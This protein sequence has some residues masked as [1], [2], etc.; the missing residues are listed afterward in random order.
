LT[1]RALEARV[2]GDTATAPVRGAGAVTCGSV[3]VNL[4]ELSAGAPARWSVVN[5]GGRP[6]TLEAVALVFRLDGAREPL[7][8]FRHGWQS[9]ST[10]GMG[11]LGVDRDPSRDAASVPLVRDLYHA[12]P[13]PVAHADELRSEWVTVLADSDPRGAPILVGFDAGATHDGTIRVRRADGIEVR[14]EAFLGGCILEPGGVRALHAVVVDDR[15]EQAIGAGERLER[16][17]ARV[18]RH[19]GARVAAPYRTGWC[20]WY[21]YFHDVTEADVRANLARAADWP[22][23]VFQ[24]DDGFQH[25]I[26]DWLRT[27]PRFPSGVDGVARLIATAGRQPGLW[28]APFL[29]AP[30]SEVA[31]THPDWLA[32][33]AGGDGPLLGMLNPPW[34]AGVMAGC[35]CS[36]RRRAP[37]RRTSRTLPA[38]SSPPA[39]P[40]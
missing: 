26:G 25:A 24:L 19:G 22:F 9:W 23:D 36:T 34:A 4:T 31:R 17:A 13:T 32:R 38:H 18:G 15:P 28:I 14:L 29:V 39:S 8:V 40:T 5:P 16:W 11:T 21:H 2:D 1:L 10:S 30:D 27:N 37:C 20:S 12:D 33:D 7:R 3:T 35:T 6:V